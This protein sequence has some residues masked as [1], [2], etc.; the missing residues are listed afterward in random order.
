MGIEP[1]SEAWEATQNT[2]K[3]SK[4]AA[5]LRLSVFSN[6]FQLEQ[7]SIGGFLELGPITQ[8]GGQLYLGAQPMGEHGFVDRSRDESRTAHEVFMRGR[9][10]VV[11]MWEAP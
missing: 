5:L 10:P 6:G 9:V 11:S 7:P 3:R 2:Q 4:L 8:G 1:T